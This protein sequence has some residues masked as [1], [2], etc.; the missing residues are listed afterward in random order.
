MYLR[1][2]ISSL[3]LAARTKPIQ[4][5]KP[6]NTLSRMCARSAYT[7]LPRVLKDESITERAVS[8]AKT[9]A[10]NTDSSASKEDIVAS[11]STDPSATPFIMQFT[12]FVMRPEDMNV[13]ARLLRDILKSTPVP[14][15]FQAVDAAM[16]RL[17]SVFAPIFPMPVIMGARLRMRMHVAPFVGV[18][19]G[20]KL[21]G[22]LQRNVN[23]LGEAV[24]GEEEAERRR[25]EA[26]MLLAKQGVDYVSVKVSGVTSQLNRWDF[27]GSLERILNSL[28]PLFRTAKDSRPRVLI[29]LDMEEYHDLELTLEAFMKLLEE[30]EFKDIDAGIVLQTYLPD[31]FPALV[32]LVEWANSRDGAAEIKIRLVKGANLA[33]EK[34]DAALHGWKQAPYET[35]AEVDANYLRCLDWVLTP[36]RLR[37]VRIGVASHNLFLLAYAH[38]LSRE[39]GLTN[40]VGFEML[41]GMTPRH[42]SFLSQQGHG[43]LLYTPVCRFKDFDVSIAYLFRR[44]EETSAD[45][46]FLRSLPTFAPG[47]LSFRLEEAR[48]RNA[49]VKYPSVAVGARREQCRPAAASAMTLEDSNVFFNEP[50]TDPSLPSNREW[51]LEVIKLEHFNGTIADSSYIASVTGAEDLVNE[52]RS[53]GAD[54]GK[55]STKERRATLVALAD[56]LARRRGD[57]IN[58]MIHEGGKTFAE[59]D[60]EVSEAIDFAQYYG[61]VCED[62]PKTFEPFGVVLVA[63]P[64]N[65]PVAIASGGVLAALAA[66]NGVILKPSNITKRCGELVAECAW[67]A[68]V[69]KNV[70]RLV[71]TPAREIGK[72]LV[73]KADAVILTGSTETA[74]LFRSWKNDLRLFAEVSLEDQSCIFFLFFFISTH[75][76]D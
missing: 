34:V 71:Q 18:F 58:A 76:Y 20:L 29:N 67:E 11:L 40:R 26:Q 64:W 47:S 10:V 25:E 3:P 1:P 42:T 41:Q 75:L 51:A 4:I 54:W 52:T 56:V 65:F 45:G 73:I 8:L 66:G 33:M 35:K 49:A 24:L 13:A 12:D 74:N 38:E 31:S 48:F 19:E 55:R 5:C 57:L 28:R 60:S 68:G 43:M 37:R 2:I 62:L 22:T 7:D 61:M 14:A 30:E 69:P 36:E 50:D 63:A 16:L 17:A 23:L 39:R 6:Y 21:D 9:W 15:F 72:E 32:K 27:E 46:N 53:A 59:A 44:F 70:L